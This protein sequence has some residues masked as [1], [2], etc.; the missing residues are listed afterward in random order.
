M[1]LKRMKNS[2]YTHLIF[3]EKAKTIDQVK[4]YVQF[5][6]FLEVKGKP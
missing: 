5:S 6:S 4:Q 2:N 1:Q 3:L